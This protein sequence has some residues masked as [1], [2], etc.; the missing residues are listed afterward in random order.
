VQVAGGHAFAR[1]AVGIQ[2]TCGITTSGDLYCWGSNEQ[3]MLGIGLGSG[4]TSPDVLMSAVPLRV[5]SGTKFKPTGLTTH[6]RLTCAVTVA[7]RPYCWGN[8]GIAFVISISS[9]T[10]QPLPG[11]VDFETIRANGRRLCGIDTAGASYCVWEGPLGDGAETG[12]LVPVRGLVA[13]P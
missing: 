7:G 6:S 13:P 10:P 8:V 11:N 3:G 5:M 2:H 4:T 1:L 9:W 12:S